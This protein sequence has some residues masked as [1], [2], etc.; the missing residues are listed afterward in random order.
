V[1]LYY[2]LTNLKISVDEK[3]SNDFHCQ[4]LGKNKQKGLEFTLRDSEGE[5]EYHPDNLKLAPKEIQ[6]NSYLKDE[7]SFDVTNL[8]TFFKNIYDIV[9]SD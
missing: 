1:E 6:T 8:K 2:S 7:L 9:N 5:I 4:L 3:D